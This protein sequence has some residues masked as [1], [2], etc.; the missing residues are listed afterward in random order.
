MAPPRKKT[1]NLPADVKV[2]LRVG[3]NTPIESNGETFMRWLRNRPRDE[4]EDWK[5]GFCRG[6][7]SQLTKFQLCVHLQEYLKELDATEGTFHR[8]ILM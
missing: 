3:Y 2:A 4:W 8:S 7:P 6:T 5:D 1:P